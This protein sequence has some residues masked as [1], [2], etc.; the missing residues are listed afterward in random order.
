M[1]SKEEPKLSRRARRRAAQEADAPPWSKDDEAEQGREDEAEGESGDADDDGEGEA[2]DGDSDETDRDS[3]E[4]DA[5]EGDAEGSADEDAGDETEAPIAAAPAAKK[6]KKKR[7]VEDEGDDPS[8]IRDRNKRLRAEAA[9][10]RRA[11]RDRER[12]SA[13]AQGLDAS[14]MVDDALARGTHAATQWVKR[15]F[16]LLQWA[17]VIS[18]AGLIGWQI[19]SWRKA[20]TT[21]KSSDQLVAGVEAE[22]GA[23]GAPPTDDPTYNPKRTFESHAARLKAAEDD[24]RAAAA[25]EAGK[26]AGILAELGLAGVLYD[27][28]KY[29][30]ALAAY[31]KVLGSALAKHDTDVR[32]RATEAVGLCKEAKGDTAGAEAAFKE[33]EGSDSPGFA[34][35]GLY[36][37]ARLAFAAGKKDEVKELLKKSKEK[38]EADKSPFATSSYLERAS[39]DLLASVDPTVARTPSSG[40]YSPE[41]LDALKAQIMQDPT[42]LK[43]MLEEMQKNVKDITKDLPAPPAS[44]LPSPPPAPSP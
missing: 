33:L 38:A 31:E 8:K 35:L 42:K 14:E 13:V 37:R 29:D 9:R 23:V 10:K 32:F 41:Q 1:A 7:A 6:K 11:K 26:G 3:D 20:R 4:G 24:Y 44:G 15:N 5:D 28:G 17:L 43:K 19:Y 36:H 27:Q 22:T 30:D 40:D 21:E 2:S 25:A 34:A 39:R 12:E 18:V 16:S